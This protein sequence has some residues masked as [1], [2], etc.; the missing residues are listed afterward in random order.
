ME[1][2][3]TGGY[4]SVRTQQ[5]KCASKLRCTYWSTS[6][7]STTPYM[8]RW[9]IRHYSR[10]GITYTATVLYGS[11]RIRRCL[12]FARS[13]YRRHS[14]IVLSSSNHCSTQWNAYFYRADV[15]FSTKTWYINVLCTSAP[16]VLPRS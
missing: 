10:D 5:K 16:L 6:G 12:S 15:S 4:G 1:H 2:R 11:I 13:L 9:W 7:V 3:T 14:S 8:L